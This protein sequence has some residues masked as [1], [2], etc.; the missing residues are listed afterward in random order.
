MGTTVTVEYLRKS[1]LYGNGGYT[2]LYSKG[3]YLLWSSRGYTTSDKLRLRT[4]KFNE[5]II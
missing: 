3:D 4:K 2:M 5:L 1:I